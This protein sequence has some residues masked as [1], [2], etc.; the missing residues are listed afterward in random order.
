M[1]EVKFSCAQ[2]GQH[3][4]ADELW[5]GHQIQCPACQNQLIVPHTQLPPV[6]AAP[7]PRPLAPQPAA[8]SRPKLSAGSTQVARS[9][10]PSSIPHRQIVR[11]P[12]NTGNQP[13]KYAVMAVLLL[14][15]GWAAYSYLPVL[16]NQVQEVGSSKTPASASA[17]PSG[18]AG[19]LGEMNG[20]MDVSDAL[21]GGSTSRP[22]AGAPRQPAVVQPR[23]TPATNILNRRTMKAPDSNK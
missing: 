9:T 7:N 1:P 8:P 16:L 23:A 13:L 14:V 2:C 17:T 18:A 21:E 3:I 15:V 22:R 20:T 4:S 19:P 10:P 11:R 5:A 12:P 6:T